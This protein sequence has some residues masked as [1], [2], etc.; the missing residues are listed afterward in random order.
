MIGDQGEEGER[1]EGGRGLRRGNSRDCRQRDYS[2][3]CDPVK[4]LPWWVTDVKSLD[5]DAMAVKWHRV[6]HNRP[7]PAL[8]DCIK[9]SHSSDYATVHLLTIY[10]LSWRSSQGIVYDICSSNRYHCLS[11]NK[12]ISFQITW[13]CW[14]QLQSCILLGWKWFKPGLV[15]EMIGPID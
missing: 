4:D 1:E 15:I 13:F 10:V 11:A 12:M 7:V 6:L 5:G 3:F 9:S 2:F 8:Q 14:G